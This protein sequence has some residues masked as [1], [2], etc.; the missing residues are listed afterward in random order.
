MLRGRSLMQTI[1]NY[2]LS[3]K[4]Y[5]LLLSL[6]AVLVFVDDHIFIL[7]ISELIASTFTNL[8]KL[9]SLPLVFLSIVTTLGKIDNF[10]ATKK[11]LRKLVSYTLITTVMASTIALL[12]FLVIRPSKNII[13]LEKTETVSDNFAYFEHIK[14]I[15]PSN[16]VQPFYENN[17]LG[18]FT[19]ALLIGLGMLVLPQK[20]RNI[21][22]GIFSSFLRLIMGIAKGIVRFIPLA[23]IAF[24]C[25][26]VRDLRSNFG[27][28]EVGLYLLSLTVS[29][30]SQALIILPLFLLSKG[31]SPFV[32]FKKMFPALIVAF[33]SK[34]SSAAMPTAI[35][36]AVKDLRIS[37]EIALFSF[38]LCTTIN[39]NA[40]AAFILTT[41]LFIC[42][43]RGIHFTTFDLIAWVLISTLAAVGNAGVPMGCYFLT[44]SL[45]STMNIPLS[46]MG[47]I[48]PFYALIDMLESAINLWSDS[49]VTAMVY[50]DLTEASK[51]IQLAELEK[52]EVAFEKNL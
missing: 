25:L 23:M 48:L 39:M 47:I 9:L 43:S 30:L 36:C 50:K 49:C 34:S 37:K 17:V 19:L 28:Q 14:N 24:F 7:K 44:C 27:M 42:E 3:K 46:L 1:A 12:A 16:F 35:D 22:N 8:L 38:P 41:V 4:Y 11:I 21:I 10:I 33:F 15:V 52:E 13:L 32:V 51:T 45:L 31:L 26:F 6:M 40:C 29:N 2:L 20:E 5:V 18:V